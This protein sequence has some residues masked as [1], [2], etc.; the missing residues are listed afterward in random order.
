MKISGLLAWKDFWRGYETAF[1]SLPVFWPEINEM[2]YIASSAFDKLK[3]KS[4][5]SYLCSII[6]DTRVPLLRD[7]LRFC[8]FYFINA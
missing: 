2:E 1:F 8:I 4:T 7:C 5:V 6:V 3:K